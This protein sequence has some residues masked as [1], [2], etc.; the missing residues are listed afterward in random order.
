M[1]ANNVRE[2]AWRGRSADL[3]RRINLDVFVFIAAF[4]LNETHVGYVD[5]VVEEDKLAIAWTWLGDKVDDLQV[6]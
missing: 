1:L 4:I 2:S 6:G 3:R 5:F